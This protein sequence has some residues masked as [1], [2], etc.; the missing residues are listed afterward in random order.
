MEQSL[1]LKPGYAEARVD[2]AR[3]LTDLNRL[4]DAEKQAKLAVEADPRSGAGH[5]IWGSLLYGQGDL[6]GAKRELSE[7]VRLQPGNWRAQVELGIV[8]A[9]QGDSAGA[10]PHLNAAAQGSD[11]DIRAAAEQALRA[12]SGR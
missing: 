6:F 7:A 10:I 2:Y 4:A 12:L 5:E 8:L 3:V 11:P 9:R 1:R